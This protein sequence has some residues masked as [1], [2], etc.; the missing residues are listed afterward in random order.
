MSDFELI[1]CGKCKVYYEMSFKIGLACPHCTKNKLR[2]HNIDD[3][4]KKVK[5]YIDKLGGND[6][7]SGGEKKG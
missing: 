4:C 6:A 7:V 2:K 5:S 3:A 1:Y